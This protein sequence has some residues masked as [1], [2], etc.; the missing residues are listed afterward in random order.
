MQF[1]DIIGQEEIIESL[2]QTVQ[3]NRISHAQLFAGE[4]GVGKLALALAYAQYIS[5]TNRSETDSCGECPSCKKYQKQIHPDLHYVF[6]VVKSSSNSKPTSDSYIKEWREMLA[7]NYSFAFN[8][9]VNKIGKE[10][11][12]AAIFVH[13]SKEIIHKLSLKTFESEYKIMIIWHPDK[14]NTVTANKLLKMI[15][16]PPPKTIFLMLTDAPEQVLGTIFS[17]SQLIKI[18]KIERKHL[19]EHLT[20]KMGIEEQKAQGIARVANGNYL[21]ALEQLQASEQNQLNF[22]HFSNLM[23][24]CYVAPKDN[25]K[26]VDLIR[27][28]DEISRLGREKQKYF[29]Q[30]ALRLFRENLAMNVAGEYSDELS[31]LANEEL[32]FS[33]KFS[34]FIH[35]QN[36]TKIYTEFNKAY[37]DITRNG[38]AKIV[39]LDLA[40]QLVKLIRIKA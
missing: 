37:S 33:Q 8:E 10:N 26:I 19:A 18:P 2:R 39:F 34:P 17:R 15:E 7:D 25:S 38:A 4:E 28:A 3:K 35:P 16:E 32:S 36:I 40:L 14:M 11:A 22:S 27:W 5:C 13:E 29:L 9:W 31:Y 24:L 23:R 21:K 30:Y 1:K 6:P 20:Q 12:Q